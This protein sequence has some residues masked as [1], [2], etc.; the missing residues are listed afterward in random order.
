MVLLKKEK[1]SQAKNVSI[2]IHEEGDRVLF[3]IE[4]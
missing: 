2:T 4:R 1:H 3:S